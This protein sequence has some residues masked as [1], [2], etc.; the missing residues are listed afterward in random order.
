[1]HRTLLEEARAAIAQPTLRSPR[2]QIIATR[3]LRY[4]VDQYDEHAKE[5]DRL[6]VPVRIHGSCKEQ[7][8]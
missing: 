8:N 7:V 2:N 5:I 4:L 6:R 3:I 1:M